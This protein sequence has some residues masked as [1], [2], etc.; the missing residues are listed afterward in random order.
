[1]RVFVPEVG[2][3]EGLAVRKSDDFLGVQFNLRPSIERDLL[4]RKLF[5]AAVANASVD[6][7]V[8]AATGMLLKSIWS[9][10]TASAKITPEMIAM[11]VIEKLPAASLVIPP[12]APA[13]RLE[14]IVADR[15]AMA[16]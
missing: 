2:F 8:I 15:R 5:T 11:P 7:S 4:I 13:I 14:E 1:V 10:P 6:I 9:A 12:R 16:A 3:V